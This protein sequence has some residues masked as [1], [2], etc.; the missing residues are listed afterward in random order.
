M[1]SSP[2]LLQ[3]ILN[4]FPSAP[5]GSKRDMC[6][7]SAIQAHTVRPSFQVQSGCGTLCQQTF[8]SYLLTVSRPISA[9]SVSSEHRTTS[10]GLRLVFIACTA[11]FFIGSYCSLFAARL[12]RYTSYYSLLVRYCSE[13]SRHRY[14]KMKMKI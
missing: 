7:F 10:C 11:L 5:E 6:R 4:Q 2:Y 8:A 12:S 14:R 3:P 9:V 1:V 13:S